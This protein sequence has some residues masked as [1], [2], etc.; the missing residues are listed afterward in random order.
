MDGS[1]IGFKPLNG[2]YFVVEVNRDTNGANKGPNVAGKDLFFFQLGKDGK[3]LPIG[4]DLTYEQI[5]SSPFGG[6]RK[7][8]NNGAGQYCAAVVIRN[9]WQMDRQYPW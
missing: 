8:L 4:N 9:S 1:C 2:D 5:S 7:D 6:C 3:L